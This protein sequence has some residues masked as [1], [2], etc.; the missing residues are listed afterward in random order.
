MSKEIKLNVTISLDDETVK[1]LDTAN[2]KLAGICTSVTEGCAAI[3]ETIKTAFAPLKELTERLSEQVEEIVKAAPE[4][5]EVLEEVEQAVETPTE[6]AQEEAVEQEPAATPI[7][8]SV[9]EQEETQPTLQEFFGEKKEN[10]TEPEPV[11]ET[12]SVSA[13]R[14]KNI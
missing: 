1:R 9:Q 13:L 10:K 8:E 6:P 4:K 14:Y 3:T 12:P 5:P 2:E 11:E 7:E